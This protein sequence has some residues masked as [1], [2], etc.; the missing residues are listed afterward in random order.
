MQATLPMPVSGSQAR[1]HTP[2]ASHD[3]IIL[4]L[5]KD[6]EASLSSDQHS[7]R[8]YLTRALTMLRQRE[9]L[10][11]TSFGCLSKREIKCVADYID[12]HLD[13]PI[14]TSQLAAVVNLSVSH[15]T[16]VFKNTF[17]VTPLSYV[18]R[19]RIESACRTMLTTDLSLTEITYR[20]GFCDQ[21]HFSR[22]FRRQI[23]IPPQN[24][25]RL[26]KL[27]LHQDPVSHTACAQSYD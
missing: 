5:L 4:L 18:A 13:A 8:L 25:R 19:Y 14:R 22:T 24:W 27:E 1:H 23:G 26:R 9:A 15:F 17:N 7:A 21:S 20:H 6:A 11:K 2:N 12:T 16:R 3:S 10:P